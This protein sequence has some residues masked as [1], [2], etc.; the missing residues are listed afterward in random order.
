MKYILTLYKSK[1]IKHRGNIF[2]IDYVVS[3]EL[4]PENTERFSLIEL[5][6]I[7]S[8]SG[9]RLWVLV[10]EIYILGLLIV[11]FPSHIGTT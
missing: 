9:T 4:S 7:D 10:S 3:T 11:L 6:S 2:K 8:A 5:L 1:I